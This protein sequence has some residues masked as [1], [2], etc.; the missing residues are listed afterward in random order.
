MSATEVAAV[1][2]SLPRERQSITHK[3]EISGH[4]GYVTVGLYDD[5]SPGEIF[6]AGFGKDGSFIQC[7]M[8]CWAKSLSNGLQYGQPVHKLVTNYLDMRFEPYGRTTNPDIP[9]AKSIPDY[10]ARWLALHFLSEEEREDHG[11][12]L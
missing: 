1:R 4:E 7:M 8:G 12:R 11:I 10:I 3:F 5:G 6:L 9:E 2:V